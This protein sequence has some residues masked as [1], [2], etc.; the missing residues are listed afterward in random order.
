MAVLALFANSLGLAQNPG[1]EDEF[2]WK[3]VTALVVGVILVVGGIVV[4]RTARNRR[5]GA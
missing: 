3:Q 2:G 5:S 4:E 1:A